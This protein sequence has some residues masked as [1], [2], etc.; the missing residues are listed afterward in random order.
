MRI[1]LP[2]VIARCDV[3]SVGHSL[4][5]QF[6]WSISTEPRRKQSLHPFWRFVVGTFP[7]VHATAGCVPVESK[8]HSR[9]RSGF[10][11]LRY[12][13]EPRQFDL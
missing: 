6:A 4:L 9:W 5:N 11:W 10:R 13:A 3:F 2:A 1:R 8:S 7:E 12:R